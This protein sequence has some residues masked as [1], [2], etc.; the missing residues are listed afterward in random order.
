MRTYCL[1]VLIHHHFLLGP[2]QPSPASII[3]PSPITTGLPVPNGCHVNR[4]RALWMLY[5]DCVD[6]AER[7][8]RLLYY[9][10]T[11]ISPNQP[12]LFCACGDSGAGVFKFDG[13]T[14]SWVGMLVGI[15]QP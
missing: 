7:S 9:I 15:D 1:L 6:S 11:L 8:K 5:G 12:Q 10:L 14:C 2:H 4:D 13:G 3:H